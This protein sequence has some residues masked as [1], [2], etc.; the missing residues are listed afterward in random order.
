MKLD[1]YDL[2]KGPIRTCRWFIEICNNSQIY[3]CPSLVQRPGR[4]RGRIQ[5]EVFYRF[6]AH[7]RFMLVKELRIPIGVDGDITLQQLR[8]VLPNLGAVS[9]TRW[10]PVSGIVVNVAVA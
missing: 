9:S 10:I 8:S 5:C 6:L 2:L 7:E 4:T 1:G 3:A